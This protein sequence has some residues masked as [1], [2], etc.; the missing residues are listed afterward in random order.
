MKKMGEYTEDDLTGWWKRQSPLG[1][2]VKFF[3]VIIILSVIFGAIGF[4]AGWFNEGKRIISP[5]NV[6]AQWQFAYDYDESLGA[7]ALQWCTAKA[8]ETAETNPDY[9]VQRSTQRIAVEN[10]YN[11]VAG[12]YNGRLRDAF[13]AKLVKPSDVPD[14]AATLEEKAEQVCSP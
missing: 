12:E 13:R 1:L 9:R 7:I 5:A 2:I 3:G 6:R 8:E 10:N 4:A 11:R 14:R